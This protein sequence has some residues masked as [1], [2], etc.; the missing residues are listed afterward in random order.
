MKEQVEP[1][2]EGK[3]RYP[4]GYYSQDG[5]DV[6]CTCKPEC[7]DPCKGKCGCEACHDAYGDF[8]SNE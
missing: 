4:N 2:E 7:V 8:L 3:R 1:T 6:P 5:I